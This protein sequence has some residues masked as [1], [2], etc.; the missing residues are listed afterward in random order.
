MFQPVK[1][2]KINILVL[3]RH[4]KNITRVLGNSGVVHLV[5]AVAQSKHNL[6]KTN[7]SKEEAEKLKSLQTRCDLLIKALGVEVEAKPPEID[8]MSADDVG[9]LLA[10]ITLKYKEQDDKIAELLAK[11]S[12]LSKEHDKLNEYPLQ[13]V[14]LDTLR[15]LSY[16]HMV[17]GTLDHDSF[18]KARQSLANDAIF[19]KVNPES[20]D[21]LIL[22]ARKNRWALQDTLAKFN[23][24][25]VDLP[26]QTDGTISEK[27]KELAA[28]IQK[29]KDQLEAYRLKILR[30]SEQYG[31]VLLAIRRQLKNLIVVEQAQVLFGK[32][33]HLYCISGW[34]PTEELDHIRDMVSQTT[35]GTGI[36]EAI[37]AD[38]DELVKAGVDQVPVKLNNSTLRRPFQNLVLN[39]STPNYHELDPSI[40]VGLTFCT[41]FGYMFGDIGQ[42]A[43]LGLIGLY[44]KF[45]KRKFSDTLRDAGTAFC[46]CSVSA[47]FF[48]FCYGSIFG[49]EIL[50][51]FWLGPL[52]QQ[53]LPKLLLT[54]VGLGIT[55]ISV[56]IM[57]NIANN[58][59]AKHYYEG[60]FDKYGIFGILFYW[61]CVFIGVNMALERPF[62]PWYLY[63]IL[64]PL[65]LIFL[66][67][68][69]HN[70]IYHHNP[71]YE[72]G[73]IGTILQASVEILETLTGFLSGTISFVR[74]GAFAISHAAL[75]L[76]VYTIIGLLKDVPFGGAASVVV[77]IFG[78]LLIIAFEGM[79][80][81]I[82][83]VRLEYYEI[84]S[85]FFQGNGMLYHPFKI[86]DNP[87]EKK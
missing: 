80:A 86:S 79:V 6:L 78:N 44:L 56:A 84:F 61:G 85:R 57:V 60:I 52:Q 3:Y 38:M 29:L 32:S 74:V 17:A 81:A 76:A 10:K 9:A 11:T 48:G 34:L 4:L 83:C 18:L 42:G 55:F 20:D 87:T 62:Q 15:N 2:C 63:L 37:D 73:F 77:F 14:R 49:S 59:L 67:L 68:P 7:Y 45:S 41:M 71:F 28:N 25:A 54:A 30:I 46:C 36:V 39:F 12:N 65:S 23:F 82:Q 21:V 50:K 40:L 72:E 47:M 13:N 70:L 16:F 5:N 66:K 35:D 26:D 64:V 43:I 33:A 58:F 22:T 8:E 31:G 27:K 69:L 24:E 75:C 51:P 1:M 19:A 53:D